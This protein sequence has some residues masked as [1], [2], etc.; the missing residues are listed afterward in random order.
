M[1]KV[2]FVSYG[3]GHIRMVVPVAEALRATGRYEPVVL[4]L[5]T[6]APVAREAGLATLQIKDFVTPQDELALAQGRRLLAGLSGVVQDPAESA[7][8]LGLSYADLVEAHGAEQAQA[9][10]ARLGRQAFLPQCMLERILRR[11][12]PD[13]VVVTNSPRAERAAVLAARSLG[14]PSVC[15]V[16]LFAL[17]EVQWIGSPDYADRVCVLNEAV[18]DFLLHA[19]R[20]PG[21]IVVTGNP[22]FD[23]LFDP[24]VQREGREL[25]EARGWRDKHVVLWASQ[26]EPAIHPFN[27]QPGNPRLPAQV[28]EALVRWALARS[29]VVL[30]LRARPGET[31]VGVPNDPRVCLTGQDWRLPPL[32]HATDMVVTLNS[33]VGLEGHLVGARL[34]QVLGS[35]FDS[36][37]PLKAY[38]IS[39]ESVPLPEL[40]ATLDRCVGLTRREVQAHVPAAAQ[41]VAVIRELLDS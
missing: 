32:L 1:K 27:G 22:A 39:D 3:G 33:T 37:M 31:I 41:V 21:Q 35:V 26:V 15:L 36:A 38:G 7:A 11:V 18:R 30:C 8:Y 13:L 34:I 12:A 28:L 16:D 24:L 6:A 29:D 2:F 20:A 4:A 19:G 10:Y 5:T 14:I 25:R 17:D 40:Q 9:L 23:A